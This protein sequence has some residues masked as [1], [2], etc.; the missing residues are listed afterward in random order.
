[1]PAQKELEVA[2]AFSRMFARKSDRS[3]A[4]GRERAEGCGRSVCVHFQGQHFSAVA[5]IATRRNGQNPAAQPSNESVQRKQ[6]R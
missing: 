6:N 3:R 4:V 2:C 1:M 5:R